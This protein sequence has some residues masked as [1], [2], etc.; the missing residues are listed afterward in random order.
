MSEN[1][2]EV[3]PAP[4]VDSRSIV[5]RGEIIEAIPLGGGAVTAIVSFKEGGQAFFYPNNS[6]IYPVAA[7]VIGSLEMAALWIDR[8][9][10]FNLIPASA[11]RPVNDQGGLL[12]EVVKGARLGL[13]YQAWE[14]MVQPQEIMKAAVL[15]YILDSRDRRKENFLIDESSHRIWLINNDYYMLLAALN[16]RDIFNTAVNRGLTDL[17]E[18]MLAAIDK[19]YAGLPS[20]LERAKEKEVLDVL[21]RA[22]AR[23]R[24]LLDKKSIANI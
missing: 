6:G 23:A 8:L 12:S 18:D 10:G 3:P 17:S 11:I 1:L 2:F 15:D 21:S 7:Q 22:Q 13:Y 5:E 19:F 4:Q 20:L 16:S 24:T 14:E 9:L